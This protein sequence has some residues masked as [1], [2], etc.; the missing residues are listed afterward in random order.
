MTSAT[1]TP[2]K[3][4]GDVIALRAC[5]IGKFRLTRVVRTIALL[6]LAFVWD[7]N[8][9]VWTCREPGN[10]LCTA[11]IKQPTLGPTGVLCCRS[12]NYTSLVMKHSFISTAGSCTDWLGLTGSLMTS[13]THQKAAYCET[14][15]GSVP[16]IIQPCK[17]TYEAKL[18][19]H[20]SLNAIAFHVVSRWC[21][22]SC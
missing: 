19:S 3:D 4:S 7:F 17:P 2:E 10:T 21:K 6:V 13:C 15:S 9:R 1:W 18:N 22:Q 16:Q 11:I 14:D 8:R 12:I 20:R 5:E